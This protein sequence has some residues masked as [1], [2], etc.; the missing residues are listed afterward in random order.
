M[1]VYEKKEV[2]SRVEERYLHTKCDICGT[3]LPPAWNWEGHIAMEQL[4][5]RT[6]E[7]EVTKCDL[8]FCEMCWRAI[9]LFLQGMG[10]QGKPK[11]DYY[12][13]S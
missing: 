1:K 11:T 4:T 13:L 5:H 8:D 10:Y 6:C 2:P 12:D 9:L 3:V 7:R